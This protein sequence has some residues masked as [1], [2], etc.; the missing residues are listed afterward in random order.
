MNTSSELTSFKGSED[1]RK[2]FYLYENVV[3][4]TLPDSER[5]E[6]I[7]AYL[8]EAALYFYFYRLALDKAPTEEAKDYSLVKKVMLE[9]FSTQKTQSK[10]MREALTLRYDIGD[11][12]KFL[13]RADKVYNQAKVGENVK[14][15]LLRDV[16]KSD[17]MLFQF[18]LFRGS[19]NYKGIKKACLKYAK[20]IKVIDRTAAPIFPKI[21]KFDKDPKETKIGE[22]CKQVENL[23]LMMMKQVR[24]LRSR[25]SQCVASM[26]RKAI[27]RRN[28]GWNKNLY[29]TNVVRMA[30][31]LLN[32]AQRSIYRLHARAAT[33][34]L[35]CCKLF[36]QEEQRSCR[37]TRCEVRQEQ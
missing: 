23:H 29:V 1:A 7:A 33:G 31:E 17:Q 2:F 15:K 5:A 9:K 10:I 12:P 35:H 30:I 20:N 11:I 25:R 27:M 6:K 13:P 8:S 19:K 37:K 36:R 28:V 18:M 32:V 22:L 26:T 24:Q 16:L 21:K 3:T 4:K 14:F 34:W